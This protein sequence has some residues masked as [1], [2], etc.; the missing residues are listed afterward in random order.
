MR[1]EWDP[2]KDRINRQKHRISFEDAIWL[3]TSGLDY[4]EVFDEA[5]SIEEDRFIAINHKHDWAVIRKIDAANGITY[6]CK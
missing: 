4:L 3:F 5:H 6:D 2:A 1:V